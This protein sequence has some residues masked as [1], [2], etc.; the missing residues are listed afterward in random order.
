MS[1]T[2][3]NCQ[4][5]FLMARDFESS[6]RTNESHLNPKLFASLHNIARQV[7]I[8]EVVSDSDEDHVAVIVRQNFEQL[9]I[10]RHR[11]CLQNPV[12]I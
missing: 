9:R 5:R 2:I 3:S 10:H 11:R 4:S 1:A 8:V 12:T 6:A 7:E